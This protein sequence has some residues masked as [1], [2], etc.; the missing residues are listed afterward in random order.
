MWQR[1]YQE[2]QTL[3]P[4]YITFPW[5]CWWNV[6]DSVILGAQKNGSFRLY[7]GM[8]FHSWC[9]WRGGHKTRTT[10]LALYGCTASVL[11]SARIK[12]MATC[13]N[14]SVSLKHAQPAIFGYS[15]AKS[16]SKSEFA[17]VYLKGHMVKYGK[18]SFA[19]YPA[20]KYGSGKFQGSNDRRKGDDF[21]FKQIPS[22]FSSPH[23][24][25]IYPWSMAIPW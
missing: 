14:P 4:W 24:P 10:H 1:Q 23:W 21:N 5:K 3:A 25:R 8:G 15:C 12:L 17:K 20:W 11:Q 22:L 6:L 9:I 16:N 7:R 18:V 2:D 13:Q 19:W